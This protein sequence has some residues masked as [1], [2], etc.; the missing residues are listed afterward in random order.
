MFWSSQS[1]VQTRR[2][3]PMIP[4]VAFFQ[5][6]PWKMGVSLKMVLENH[7]RRKNELV[8]CFLVFSVA[9]LMYGRQRAKSPEQRW[10][11]RGR[12]A[13]VFVGETSTYSKR[14]RA[15]SCLAGPQMARRCTYWCTIDIV[16]HHRW[17][18][19]WTWNHRKMVFEELDVV[20]F[21]GEHPAMVFWTVNL[22][23][24]ASF[25]LSL[26]KLWFPM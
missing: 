10:G 20:Y 16:S 8:V 4:N 15:I 25:L 3:C 14:A 18:I 9:Q 7:V 11:G 24:S 12:W 22:N 17:P 2:N 19:A 26:F 21:R 5:A 13:R 23:W 1:K 6:T